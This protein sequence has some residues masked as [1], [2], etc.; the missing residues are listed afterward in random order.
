MIEPWTLKGRGEIKIKNKSKN[1][2]LYDESYNSNPQAL[3][4]AINNFKN[5]IKKIIVIGDM[6]E[7]GDYS[8][9]FHKNIIKPIIKLM[10]KLVIIVGKKDCK[11]INELLPKTIKKSSL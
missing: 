1:F 5:K 3:E 2:Y 6:L 8:K 10:P 9:K 11:I 7:L 4:S